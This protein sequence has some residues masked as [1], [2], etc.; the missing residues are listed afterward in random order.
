VRRTRVLTKRQFQFQF[1]RQNVS[2]SWYQARSCGAAPQSDG[3]SSDRRLETLSL[4]ITYPSR[5]NVCT[6]AR[7]IPCRVHEA[8]ERA[9][10]VSEVALERHPTLRQKMP[11]GV[12][13]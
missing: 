11:V 3:S 9:V 13:A 7:M 6:N 10:L 2:T 8:V 12:V 1:Y 5:S 4:P